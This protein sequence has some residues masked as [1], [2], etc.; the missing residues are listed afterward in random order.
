MSKHYVFVSSTNMKQEAAEM[1]AGD[2]FEIRVIT[3]T[4]RGLIPQ[5]LT[6]FRFESFSTY[7]YELIIPI[8][9][10]MDK[11]KQLSDH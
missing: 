4:I 11:Y 2:D 5:S 6:L 8:L 10:V 9:R 1:F 7:Q 3:D